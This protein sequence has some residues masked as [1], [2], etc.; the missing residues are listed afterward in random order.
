[1][2]LIV[3]PLTENDEKAFRE[4]M[5]LFA[6]ME[7]DWYSFLWKDG[8]TFSDHVKLLNAR[9]KGVDVPAGRVPDSML[10]AFLEGKIVGRISIRHELNEYLASR[11][12]HLGYAVAT[13]YRQK[14]IGAEILKQGLVYCKEK[15]NLK[16]V[17]ITCSEENI[18]SIKVIEKNHP[19]SMEK[20]FVEGEW[21]RKYWID[22]I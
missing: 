12:G 14:G 5:S 8:D 22:L 11:G 13:A 21:I 19:R 10:Y 20:V 6:D 7:K 17:L 15:L 16:E 1:M 3:R 2:E 4:G 9:A 18:G